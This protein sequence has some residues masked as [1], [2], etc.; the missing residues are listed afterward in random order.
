[1]FHLFLSTI[2][3]NVLPTFYSMPPRKQSSRAPADKPQEIKV[4]TGSASKS[5][6]KPRRVLPPKKEVSASFLDFIE[7]PPDHND[8]DVDPTQVY[9]SILYS[10]Y[11]SKSSMVLQKQ[12]SA[13]REIA[14]PALLDAM[15]EFAAPPSSAES[16]DNEKDQV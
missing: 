13:G 1:M 16:E 7:P 8:M 5:A 6:P 9:H 11:L 3:F 4:S 10:A 14:D 12:S 15:C 2:Y